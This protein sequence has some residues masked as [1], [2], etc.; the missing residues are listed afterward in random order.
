[1]P[2]GIYAKEKY[3]KPIPIDLRFWKYVDKKGE[4]ECWN[5]IGF[6]KQTGYGQIRGLDKNRKSKM[7]RSHRVSWILTNGEIPDSLCVLHKCDN[8]SCVNP[9]HLFLGTIKDNVQDMIKKGRNFLRTGIR[10]R[11]AKLKEHE[12]IEIINSKKPGSFLSKL[13]G[14]SNSTIYLI[15]GRGSWKGLKYGAV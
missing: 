1:M 11:R 8:P 6:K 5:W 12:V 2:K 13:Y 3:R 14:V 10:I 15:K 4:N 9:K 7:L